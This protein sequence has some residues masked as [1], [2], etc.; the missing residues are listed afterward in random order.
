M[1]EGPEITILS[2]YLTTVLTGKQILNISVL[3][4]KYKKDQTQFNIL[5]NAAPL[6]IINIGSKGKQMFIELKTNNNDVV[7]L[8]TH[9][10]LTGFWTINPIVA[11]NYKIDITI[12][13]NIKLMYED[14]SNFGNMFVCNQTEFNKKLDTLALDIVKTNISNCELFNIFKQYLTNKKIKKTNVVELLMNQHAIISG[15]GNYLMAEILYRAKISPFT[16]VRDLFDD[17]ILELCESIRYV[18]KLSYFNNKTGY[19]THFDNV[20]FKDQY[21]D[22]IDY[23]RDKIGTMYPNYH[24]NVNLL[25][26]VFKFK[27]YGCKI[28]EA[29]NKIEI[30]KTIQDGRSTYWCPLIQ[31]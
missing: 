27:I 12:S 14:N 13:D 21:I 29:G 24:A 2:Q 11:K 26:D 1:P 6:T 30:D 20:F 28:D 23:H 22:F 15:I 4:G 18:V 3:A 25:D 9:L 7:Y 17:R 5:N 31:L 8:M 16:N 10:G 19:M